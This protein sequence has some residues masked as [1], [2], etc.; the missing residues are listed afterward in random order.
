MEHSAPHHAAAAAAAEHHAS[1]LS[2]TPPPPPLPPSVHL[3]TSAAHV[4]GVGTASTNGTHAALHDGTKG[5]AG[6]GRPGEAAHHPGSHI[7][8]HSKLPPSGA[9]SN[10][11]RPP[12]PPPTPLP[13]PPRHA[14]NTSAEETYEYD[15]YDEDHAD[16][17]E[18]DDAS[19]SDEQTSLSTLEKEQLEE[20]L[21]FELDIDEDRD[22]PVFKVLVLAITACA[23]GGFCRA[24]CCHGSKGRH[25]LIGQQPIDDMSPPE[26]PIARPQVPDFGFA[27][28]RGMGVAPI[29]GAFE[30]N[31]HRADH[32]SRPSLGGGGPPSVG[33]P[34]P[35]LSS[36]HLGVPPVHEAVRPLDGPSGFGG[37]GKSGHGGG[38]RPREETFKSFGARFDVFS[39]IASSLEL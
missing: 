22:E 28:V 21:W 15:E 8:G 6:I 17:T 19:S 39:R 26:S 2:Q 30:R 13:P 1:T 34:A 31:P 5:A 29:A 24:H 18:G 16:D 11:P 38:R 20:H 14:V 27:D 25:H 9:A 12:P 33:L 10:P 37:V 3:H 35:M 32:C 23:I 4:H 36:H 7:A